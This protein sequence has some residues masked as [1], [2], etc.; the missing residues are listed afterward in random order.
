[1]ALIPNVGRSAWSIRMF[2][3]FVY[4]ALAFL[5]LTMVVPFL[6]TVANSTTNDFDYERFRPIP[7][8]V[9]SAN[10]RFVKGLVPYFNVFR[11]WNSQMAI[12]SG[13]T[14]D[15]G[16]VDL[17]APAPVA[18]SAPRVAEAAAQQAAASAPAAAAPAA[19]APPPPPAARIQSPLVGAL[20]LIAYWGVILGGLYRNPTTIPGSLSQPED[21]ESSP[22]GD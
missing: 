14:L 18:V 3:V 10:D 9:W 12:Q 17:T 13:Q 2:I 8:Y 15:L 5:G 16:V 7:R 21:P 1:M 11:G 6:I 4:V 19:P 20:V 22:S